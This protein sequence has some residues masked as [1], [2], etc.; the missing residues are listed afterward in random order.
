MPSALATHCSQRQYHEEKQNCLHILSHIFLYQGLR[1][2]TR[3]N[4]RN[5][6]RNILQRMHGSNAPKSHLPARV[7]NKHQIGKRHRIKSREHNYSPCRVYNGM[8]NRKK[9]SRY[10]CDHTL[11]IKSKA[12]YP[13][14][15]CHNVSF[16]NRRGNQHQ[17]NSGS[18]PTRGIIDTK[19]RA[20]KIAP[21]Q[22]HKHSQQPRQRGIYQC[23]AE[24][25]KAG[26]PPHIRH[27]CQANTADSPHSLVC[28]RN[29][30]TQHVKLKTKNLL[31]KIGGFSRIRNKNRTH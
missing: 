12:N 22:L 26:A 20:G 21:G 2:H 7:A 24:N 29:I 31:I 30:Q 18:L 10:N 3:K 14:Q 6:P 17:E 16:N 19:W 27:Y 11:T 8:K 23:H 13:Y 1:L 5:G 4:K 15:S 28:N 25:I 9:A